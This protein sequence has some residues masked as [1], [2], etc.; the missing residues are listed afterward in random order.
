MVIVEQL[1]SS[2][3]N[4]SILKF[5][6]LDLANNFCNRRLPIFSAGPGKIEA[7]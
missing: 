2:K 6:R 4:M 7:E 1:K 3:I 5:Y